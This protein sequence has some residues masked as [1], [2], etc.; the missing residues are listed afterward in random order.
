[1]RE[2]LR[3]AKDRDADV[4]AWLEMIEQFDHAVAAQASVEELVR[5]AG[6]MTGLTVGVR[7]EWNRV[8]VEVADGLLRADDSTEADVALAAA[9]RGLRRRGAVEI[10]TPRGLALVAPIEV[11]AGRVGFAWVLS[12]AGDAWEPGHHLVV[13]R[14]AGAVAART[15]EARKRRS[16]GFDPAA[17]ERLLCVEL[18]DD[19]L[20]RAS[21]QAKLS[22]SDRYIGVALAQ[23]PADA[24]PI[25]TL[26]GIV[27]QAI[28]ER[29]IAARAAVIGRTA[30]VVARA[31]S[32]LEGV[33]EELARGDAQLGFR[34]HIG[35]GDSR[36]LRGLPVSWR[37]AREAL[38]L[39][40]LLTAADA[41][42]YFDRLGVL[43]LL[44]QIPAE[45]V[46]ASEL[47]RRLTESL[48][49]AGSPSDVDVLEAYLE[50]GTLRRAGDR[51]FLHHTTVQHRLR[52]LEERL[53]VDLSDP[54]SRFQVQ[55][56]V[57]LL[58]IARVKAAA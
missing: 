32:S 37:H 28:A 24:V 21:R 4:L 39:R 53:Q 9:H 49:G 18:S 35:V 38:A 10:D 30:A 52:S 47:L 6:D 48:D 17:V 2:I 46:L 1:V 3:A 11:A 51:V 55:L 25:E 22:P 58:A 23:S 19:E 33:L 41:P 56:A 45:H 42:A 16:G 8:Q 36:D 5:L 26:A 7:D 12:Q 20:A 44:A 50:E 14:L 34:I 40:Q 54:A 13:E 43:H 57:K 15:L 31:S 29:Q 27:Q